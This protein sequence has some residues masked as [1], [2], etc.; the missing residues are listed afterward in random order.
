MFSQ[1]VKHE[2]IKPDGYVLCY[3]GIFKLIFNIKILSATF[4]L[5]SKQD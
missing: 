1:T 4:G 2:Q 5:T 3:L